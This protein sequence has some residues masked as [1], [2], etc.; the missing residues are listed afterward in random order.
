MAG[1]SQS[2]RQDQ[3]HVTY[4]SDG[5]TE[6]RFTVLEEERGFLGRLPTSYRA[7]TFY[8]ICPYFPQSVL[9]YRLR[10]CQYE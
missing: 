3:E 7:Y 5:L 4:F 2:Y 9:W 10:D 1:I 8:G 6:T